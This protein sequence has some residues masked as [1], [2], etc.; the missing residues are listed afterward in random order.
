MHNN[1]RL[2]E[3]FLVLFFSLVPQ[4]LF[5]FLFKRIFDRRLFF[6]NLIVLLAGLSR[7]PVLVDLLVNPTIILIARVLTGIPLPMSVILLLAAIIV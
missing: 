7:I 3:F 5:G 4:H 1:F 2:I 6:L